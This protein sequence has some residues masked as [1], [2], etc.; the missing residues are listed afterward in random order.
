MKKR[1]IILT[2]VFGILSVLMVFSLVGNILSL[3]VNAVSSSELKNQINELETQ[4]EHLDAQLKKWEEQLADNT[5]AIKDI[6][7]RKAIIEQQLNLLREQVRN[8]NTQLSAYAL[9]IA[10]KQE[11]LDAAENNLKELN[12][13]FRVRIRAME[14]NGDLSYW[15]VLFQASSFA[16]FLDR[17]NMIREIAQSDRQ[18]LHRMKEAADAVAD[19]KNTL[20]EERE[21]LKRSKAELDTVLQTLD[22]KNAETQQ[23][24]QELLERE[25]EYQQLIQ[26][27]ESL[28]NDLLDELAKKE[29]EYDKA[30]AEEAY[31]QWLSTSVPPTEATQPSAPGG[32]EDENGI[33]WLIPTKYRR[34]SSVF[35]EERLHPILGYVRPHKGIDLAASTGTPIYATRS[36]IVTR[37]EYGS[38]NGNFVFI[39]HGDGFTSVYLHM[40]EYIV[41]PGQ[42]VA[43]GEQIGTVGNTG[44]S[45]GAHLH[46]SIIRDGTYV[47]PALY[48]EF[49]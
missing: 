18:R 42:Y 1:S 9:L 44:L 14:E 13:K 28:Q 39:N 17:L 37:A 3:R 6:V 20:Q 10:D 16:E 29:Q 48:V 27:N 30:L 5:G 40:D 15:N 38:A 32:N 12:E 43:Q 22:A 47:N 45:K 26:E 4:K 8:I 33:Y 31:Q 46:F 21:Q 24:M 36:G 11:E 34:V 49:Y 23:L 2:V 35:T 41:K 7:N 19:A 25:D